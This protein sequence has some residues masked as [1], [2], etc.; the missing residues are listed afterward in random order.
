MPKRRSLNQRNS[1]RRRARNLRQSKKLQAKLAAW[2]TAGTLRS[3]KPG[4]GTLL[5]RS[6]PSLSADITLDRIFHSCKK[7]F[8]DPTWSVPDSYLPTGGSSS[9]NEEEEKLNRT[10]EAAPYEAPSPPLILTP[11]KQPREELV[12]PPRDGLSDLGWTTP[13]RIDPPQPLLSP[14]RSP[15]ALSY[16]EPHVM[17]RNLEED[18]AISDSDQ[19]STGF[20]MRRSPTPSR[21]SANAGP[22]SGPRRQLFTLSPEEMGECPR[23]LDMPIL[24]PKNEPLLAP[25]R[26]N[27]SS[28]P[29]VKSRVTVRKLSLQPK[30]NRTRLMNIRNRIKAQRI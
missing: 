9:F 27:F 15:K 4:Q 24:C 1:D 16:S 13:P 14:I 21:R 6:Q 17:D 23:L 3:P 18:L 19:D 5:D 12:P 25:A 26:K 28:V 11:V 7:G 29:L 8:S 2:A 10:L 22:T 30:D 20:A